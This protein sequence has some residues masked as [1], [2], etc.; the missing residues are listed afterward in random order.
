MKIL[1]E[2]GK[3][4]IPSVMS[5]AERTISLNPELEES[6]LSSLDS[7]SF[8]IKDEAEEEL[9]I[10]PTPTEPSTRL[11]SPQE[12]TTEKNKG[13]KVVVNQFD[14]KTK[15][16]L[17]KFDPNKNTCDG[18]IDSSVFA[19]E[20]GGVTDEKKIVSHLMLAVQARLQPSLR[21]LMKKEMEASNPPA[22]VSVEIFKKAL[23]AV[24]GKS[25]RD[26][27]N[28]VENLTFSKGH[29]SSMREFYIDLEQYLKDLNPD[30]EN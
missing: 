7:L 17:A 9:Y 13:G 16:E 10:P 2:T 8:N 6:L 18:W 25:K 5:I 23:Q 1:E 26:L 14:T 20:L 27:D 12:D 11:S 22:A 15:S 19:L 28:I 21:A 3:S 4:S 24:A 30:I 29:Y